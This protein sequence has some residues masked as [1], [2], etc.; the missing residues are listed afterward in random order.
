MVEERSTLSWC[1]R[2]REITFMGGV[3]NERGK[4]VERDIEIKKRQRREELG[5]EPN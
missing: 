2:S 3:R 1:V 5:E 4:R